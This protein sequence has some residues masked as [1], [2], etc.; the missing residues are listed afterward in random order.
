MHALECSAKSKRA[1]VGSGYKSLAKYLI[2]FQSLGYMPMAIDVR[3][4]DDGDG[5]R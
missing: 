5:L 2:Q 3:R 4:I 1:A